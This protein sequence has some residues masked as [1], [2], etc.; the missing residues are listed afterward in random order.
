M[1]NC[2]QCDETENVA[3]FTHFPSWEREF[4]CWD[5]RWPLIRERLH[6]PDATGPPG[7]VTVEGKEVEETDLSGQVSLADFAN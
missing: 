5:C 1:K 4:L 3:G 7:S 6:G 2:E